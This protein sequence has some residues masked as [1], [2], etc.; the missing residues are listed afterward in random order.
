VRNQ[1][2]WV[3][4]P[5][6][7][8]HNAS[9]G[10]LSIVHGSKGTVAFW[11]CPARES[12]Y[13]TIWEA[14]AA[15]N[16]LWYLWIDG[17]GYLVLGVYNGSTRREVTSPAPLSTSRWDLVV[18]S[19]DFTPTDGVGIITLRCGDQAAQT[20]S[21]A[22][23]PRQEATRMT[24]GPRTTDTAY[25]KAV[26]DNLAIWNGVMTAD[27]FTAARGDASYFLGQTYARRRLPQPEDV[28]DASALT[29]LATWD[30]SYDAVIGGDKTAQ[31]DVTAPNYDQFCRL[32][33]SSP[34]PPLRHQFFF[35][36]PRHDNTPDDRVPLPAV[37]TLISASGND[38]YTT[39]DNVTE[40]SR[41]KVTQMKN[42]LYEGQGYHWLRPWLTR[43]GAG[44]NNDMWRPLTF[45]LQV[46]VP[47]GIE[48][49]NPNRQEVALGPFIWYTWKLS[50]NWNGSWGP[51]R[52]GKVV[53]DAGNST[54]QIKTDITGDGDDYWNGTWLTFRSGAGLGYRLQ[55]LDYTSTSG[56]FTVSGALPEIPA[57][58]DRLL[59]DA[60]SWLAATP[61]WNGAV[62]MNNTIE[63][64]LSESW[65]GDPYGGGD[66]ITDYVWTKL[67]AICGHDTTQLV[68]Y[69]R[70]RTVVMPWLYGVGGSPDGWKF[71]FGRRMGSNPATFNAEIW[72][73]SLTIRGG[74]AYDTL[75]PNP[76][77]F[78]RPAQINDCFMAEHHCHE[79]TDSGAIVAKPVHSNR[80]WRVAGLSR[81]FATMT[82]YASWAEVQASFNA[83]GTWRHT[84]K[85]IY[86][87]AP[88]SEEDTII[89]LVQGTS[90]GGVAA[91][92]YCRGIWDAVNERLTWVDET[93]P[94]GKVN[95]FLAQSDL[96]PELERDIPWG[97]DY[98]PGLIA[99]LG[100]P[101][102]T[103]VLTYNGNTDN[104]D[105]YVTRA[106]FA[107][108]R[109]SFSHAASWWRDNPLPMGLHGVD[110]PGAWGNAGFVGNR[111]CEW[112]FCF[113]PVTRIPDRR[114][115]GG[116]RLKSNV[117]QL[118]GST[119]YLANPIRHMGGMVS[120]DFRGFRV[121]PHGEQV[122]PLASAQTGG[123][124]HFAHGAD[125]L[126][127]LTPYG[128]EGGT[129][130][131][132]SD[133]HEHWQEPVYTW[134]AA[135]LPYCPPFHLG[136]RTIYYIGDGDH[137]GALNQVVMD[138]D[139]E[140]YYALST[141][142]VAGELL[143][144]V[145]VKPL[146]GWAELVV[147]A[148]QNA[149]ALAVEILDPS[150]DT[151]LTG[152]AMADMDTLADGVCSEVTWGGQQ[153]EDLVVGAIRLRFIF[154]RPGS[155]DDSPVLYAWYAEGHRSFSLS[156]WP[157][158]PTDVVYPL[159]A[160]FVSQL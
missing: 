63:A 59:V 105:H 91:Y 150:T 141:G 60:R 130:L 99:V 47:T 92:G 90:A 40:C 53:A 14:R 39:C 82:K 110:P 8:Y 102:G 125:V 68:R 144:P 22:C 69:N 70:G 86:P 134:I 62:D 58:N 149:G 151:P 17:G 120:G 133:D 73:E 95:P 131:R 67:E 9:P 75:D 49:I 81:G 108:D 98:P 158:V 129:R 18:A 66:D 25:I 135:A 61:E 12:G 30:G 146:E 103:W 20:R 13:G 138:R 89:M 38:Q 114:Y 107:A 96:T 147:N 11:F 23:A 124:M 15:N 160:S 101:D 159:V 43:P 56:I 111:D 46:H 106:L 4:K 55:V 32:S 28:A 48:P 157:P 122:Q 88:R 79:V 35:G 37:L 71:C 29:F 19:W 44:R 27:E 145:L 5:G 54:T 64:W 74:G 31:W 76:T 154:S 83:T 26:F 136:E 21:D 148:A 78:T 152:F 7:H 36:M 50:G 1:F 93:P 104:P 142:Q 65:T 97:A 139:R 34:G 155:G 42:G 41:V 119:D 117:P 116:G 156:P 10:N 128:G 153:L 45:E 109:W 123:G 51:G 112:Q 2:L 140:T 16:D 33:D 113:D 85:P 121:L 127:H 24:V 94:A 77:P 118:G 126:L 72:V 137:A 3:N 143:T 57:A 52:M 115:F 132:V 100:L 87:V 6:F 80:A 84:G